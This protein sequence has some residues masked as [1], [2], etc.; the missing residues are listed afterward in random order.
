MAKQRLA[1][2]TDKDLP[3][4]FELYHTAWALAFLAVWYFFGFYGVLLFL[5]VAGS[6]FLTFG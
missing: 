5:L 2:V 1:G 3:W 4:W 6:V